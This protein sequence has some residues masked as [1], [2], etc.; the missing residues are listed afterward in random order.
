MEL[1]NIVFMG[2][3]SFAVPCLELLSF[4]K[5]K[6]VLCITQPDKPKGRNRKLSPPQIKV[7][8]EELNIP[9]IQ[10]EDVNDSEVINYLNDIKPDIIIA[11][12]YGG[13]LKKEI[14]KLPGFGCI[15]L[16]PSLLPKYRGSSPISYALFNDE[17]VTGNTVIKIVA[18]MD[19]GP[20]LFQREVKIKEN[21]CYTE[22]YKRLSK[23]GAEDILQVLER[24]EKGEIKQKKQDENKATLT[25]KIMKEDLIIDWHNPAKSIHSKVRGLAEKPGAV[26]SISGKRIKIIET[27]ILKTKTENRPGTIKELIKNIGLVVATMD[28]DILIKRVQPAG[29]KIMNS[30]AFNLGARLGIGDKFENGF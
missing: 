3:P 9:L 18:K 29:K 11:V 14:R 16:H 6:P 21:E 2:T 5:F 26:A 19:A 8:A 13:F 28:Y 15:N 27:E 17:K 7:K 1:K 22:L 10:P 12:A 23:E 25:Q 4:T 20:I 30:F 24:F